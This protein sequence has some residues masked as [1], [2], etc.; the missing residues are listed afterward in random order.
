MNLEKTLYRILLGYY[1]I[2]IDEEEYKVIY[3]SLDIKYKAELLYTK[4][5]E[6]NKFDKRLLTAKE[7]DFYLKINNIWICSDEQALVDTKKLIEN[8]KIDLYTN[9]INEKTKNKLK[10]QLKNVNKNLDKLL[11]DKNSMNHLS[12]EDHAISIKNE[13]IIMNSIYDKNNRLV[14]DNPNKDSYAHQ[15]LQKFI[16]EIL[17]QSLDLHII[18][19]I[20]KS[21][22]WRS[23][24]NCMDIQKDPLNINDDYRYLIGLHKMYD[25]VRQ[26]PECPSE[27]IL[28]DDDAL[29]GWFLYNNR[30][31]EKEKKKNAVLNKVRGNIKNAGEVFVIT[32]DIQETKEIF[33]LNDQAAKQ[34]IKEMISIA[35]AQPDNK[36]Y[37]VDWNKLPFVQRELLHQSQQLNDQKLGKK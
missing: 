22:I 11:S 31:A 6:D 29:D 37:S 34:N 2:T 4:T 18:R 12:I 14:F 1:Y 13:F 36:D 7:I 26:H 21:D 28:E 27:D 16:R 32:D 25:N 15:K 23:Y 5:I 35:N 30:K 33:S 3:P 9:Y 8:I 20:A 24:V 17:D 10:N 19:S